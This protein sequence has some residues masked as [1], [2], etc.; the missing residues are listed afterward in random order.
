[1]NEFILHFTKEHSMSKLNKLLSRKTSRKIIPEQV[2][3][4]INLPLFLSD[5]TA[6]IQAVWEL[7]QENGER[8]AGAV[9]RNRIQFRYLPEGVHKLTLIVGTPLLSKGSKVYQ[10][11]I[12]VNK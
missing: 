3:F 9:K 5:K 6:K 12:K 4:D 10:C 11:L 8:D 7:E 2:N 1:M